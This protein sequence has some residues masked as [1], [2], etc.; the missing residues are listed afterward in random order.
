MY[1]SFALILFSSI[2]DHNL[3]KKFKLFEPKKNDSLLSFLETSSILRL[4]NPE[5][6]QTYNISFLKYDREGM[7]VVYVNSVPKKIVYDCTAQVRINYNGDLTNSTYVVFGS[8][9]NDVLEVE[10]IRKVEFMELC[11]WILD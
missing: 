4:K 9:V 5:I 3:K 2:L 10:S 11:M 8:I 7:Y 1:I 6:K